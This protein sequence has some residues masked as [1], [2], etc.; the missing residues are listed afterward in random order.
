MAK[1]EILAPREQEAHFGLYRQS[2]GGDQAIIIRR[3]IGEETDYLHANSRKLQR[4][5]EYLTLASQH[6]ARLTPTQKAKTRHQFEEVEFI[7]SHGKTDTKLL[8]GRQ[9]FIAKEMRS[10]A[11]TGKQL[12]TPLEICII[13]TDEEL[14]P[15]AGQLWLKYLLDEEWLDCDRELLSQTD[16]LFPSVPAGMI[17]YHPYGEAP[18]YLDE[19]DPDTTFLE[20]SQLKGYHYHP[21][22]YIGDLIELLFT[23]PHEK[24][25]FVSLGWY[26]DHRF[27][28]TE[29]LEQVAIYTHMTSHGFYGNLTTGIKQDYYP[30]PPPEWIVSRER[31]I[32][33]HYFKSY[34]YLTIL[35]ATALVPNTPY[36][37]NL[38]LAN[39]YLPYWWGHNFIWLLPEAVT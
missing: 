28:P 4:Q 24:R 23:L 37:L 12:T 25:E 13:L 10:L 21:L 6:Y 9:L 38:T 5:R 29:P 32:L 3:K 35:P 36:R 11:T 8:T 27:I 22:K 16:W 1:V 33:Q 18:G 17:R 14:N 20:E 19:E 30:P 31:L 39:T 26:I 15:I 2:V 7:A 34:H